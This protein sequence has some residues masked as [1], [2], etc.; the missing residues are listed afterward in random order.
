MDRGPDR[1]SGDGRGVSC[2]SRNNC[3]IFQT[4]KTLHKGEAGEKGEAE[5]LT[6]RIFIYALTQ[7]L[8]PDFMKS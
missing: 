7:Y 2:P 8:H 3:K 1:R 5:T 4:P 6:L